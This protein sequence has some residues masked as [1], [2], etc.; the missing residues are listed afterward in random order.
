MLKKEQN[1]NQGIPWAN[2]AAGE[3]PMLSSIC[4]VVRLTC[5]LHVC[6]NPTYAEVLFFGTVKSDPEQ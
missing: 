2:F 4:A 1:L 5:S 6:T 3:N